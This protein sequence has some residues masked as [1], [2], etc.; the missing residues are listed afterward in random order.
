M[1]QE[2]FSIIENI[3]FQY[4]FNSILLLGFWIFLRFNMFMPKFIIIDQSNLYI[5]FKSSSWIME[6][7]PFKVFDRIVEVDWNRYAKEIIHHIYM[8]LM[9]FLYTLFIYLMC[10]IVLVWWEWLLYIVIIFIS[11]TIFYFL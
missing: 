2:V 1:V 6:S 7:N 10:C 8:I 3:D 4:L 5:L 11:N 9:I